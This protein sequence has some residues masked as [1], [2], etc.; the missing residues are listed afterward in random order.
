MVDYIRDTDPGDD[1]K[2]DIRDPSVVA[3]WAKTLDVT[4]TNLRRAV[5]HAGPVVKKV[6]LWLQKNRLIK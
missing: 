4:Q 6:K 3:H 5:I 2:I 1:A